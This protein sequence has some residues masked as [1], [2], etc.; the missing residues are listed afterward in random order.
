MAASKARQDFS[1]TLNQVAYKKRRI[2]L[3]RR[4]KDVAALV[5]VEDLALIERIEDR[6]D[7]EEAEKILS[8][9]ER[10]GEKP[11]AWDR[12]KRDLGLEP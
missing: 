12:V 4:G 1:E 9:M 3:H 7:L 5:P 10:T 8:E 6:I 2:L 11:I